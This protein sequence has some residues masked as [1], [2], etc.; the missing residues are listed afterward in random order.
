MNSDTSGITEMDYQRSIWRMRRSILW[1]GLA[2]I[3]P[4]FYWIG[5]PGAFGWLC[6]FL[7]SY[8]NFFWLEKG[9]LAGTSS[10]TEGASPGPA[11]RRKAVGRFLLRYILVGLGAYVI[12][13]SSVHAAYGFF[14]ALALP[15]AA[16]AVEAAIVIAGSLRQSG[17]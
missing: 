10:F 4:C 17:S 16:V 9:V 12:F 2:G 14:G 1:L 13:E 11:G 8:L 15:V 6:G 7:V 5:L 3:L